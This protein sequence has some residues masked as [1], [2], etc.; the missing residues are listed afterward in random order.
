MSEIGSVFSEHTY[1]EHGMIEVIA[2]EKLQYA[3][4]VLDS[5]GKARQAVGSALARAAASGKT[6]A[7][8]PI[9]EEYT[10]S[11]SEF[12]AQTKNINYFTRLSSGEIRVSFGFRGHVIPLTK[13]DTRVD[14]SGRVVTRVKRTGTAETLNHA[15]AA[16]IGG[17]YG[18]YERIGADRFPVRQLY[19]PSTPQMIGADK[20]VSDAI[21]NKA[22]ETFKKRIDHEIVRAFN[23]W[24]C[25]R[26]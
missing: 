20:A 11:A 25:N 12:L 16:R 19:G 4:G 15:F 10:L 24:G 6:A 23:G 17:H 8:K 7:K 2:E 1:G 21:E 26:K 14:G 3:I 18:I 5:I 13:F 22:I 9:T